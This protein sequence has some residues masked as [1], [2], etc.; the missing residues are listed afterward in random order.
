MSMDAIAKNLGLEVVELREENEKL[1]RLLKRARE[2]MAEKGI[3]AS[4]IPAEIDAVILNGK[5][6]ASD[7]LVRW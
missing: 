4:D 7:V 3:A 5:T 1:V 2:I 6:T